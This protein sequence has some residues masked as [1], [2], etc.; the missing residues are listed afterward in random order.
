MRVWRAVIG[1][2]ASVLILSGCATTTSDPAL[3]R[4]AANVKLVSAEEKAETLQ[5]AHT[6]MQEIVGA[7]CGR[8]LGSDPSLDAA[9]EMLRVEAAKI[10]ADAVIDIAC[11][12]TG[13]NWGRNCWKS[14][15]CRGDAVKWND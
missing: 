6:V 14:I 1:T 4:Q 2:A 11:E 12:E 9:R 8:Q 10:G 13:V 5:R 3:R 15:E 7:S